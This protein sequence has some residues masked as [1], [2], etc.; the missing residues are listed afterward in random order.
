MTPGLKAINSM[1][2]K[3]ASGLFIADKLSAPKTV[4]SMGML[5]VC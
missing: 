2:V 4:V 5:H 1:R 3:I